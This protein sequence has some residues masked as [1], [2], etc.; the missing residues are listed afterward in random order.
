MPPGLTKAERLATVFFSAGAFLLWIRGIGWMSPRSLFYL[1]LTDWLWIAACGT[2]L[3]TM[4]QK[5]RLLFRNEIWLAAA[6]LAG[7]E[8]IAALLSDSLLFEWKSALRSFEFI[9]IVGGGAVLIGIEKCKRTIA[10]WFILGGCLAL[11]V[12]LLGFAIRLFFPLGGEG[13]Y[14]FVFVSSHSLFNYWP[15]LT[16]TFGA[17]PEHFGEYLVGLLAVFCS[18]FAWSGDWPRNA[19]RVFIVA[20]IIA[21]VMTFSYAWAGAIVV[22]AGV[23]ASSL[24]KRPRV[25]LLLAGAALVVVFVITLAPNLGPV[26]VVDDESA[27]KGIS[28]SAIDAH[29]VAYANLDSSE[30]RCRPF[31]VEWPYRSFLT[32]YAQAKRTAVDVIKQIFPWG[33]GHYHYPQEADAAAKRIYGSSAAKHYNYP[34]CIYLSV[35][36]TMGIIGALAFAALAVSVW[37]SRSY[38]IGFRGQEAVWYGLIGWLV[39]GINGEILGDRCFWLLLAFQSGAIGQKRSQDS[40]S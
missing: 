1:N 7:S 21:I 16:G 27:R 34:Y 30:N 31:I 10:R 25:R 35:V 23:A 33:T 17:S 26:T 3:P 9:A 29:H 20:V 18:R 22:L 13:A 37:R 2:L 11:A 36:A 4:W 32:T 40:D 14:L 6:A 39:I 8:I 19:K 12:S 38:T 15:R 24:K 5:R 28:C